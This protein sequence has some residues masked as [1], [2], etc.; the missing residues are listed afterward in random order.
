MNSALLLSTAAV[1]GC[2]RNGR[3][4]LFNEVLE[5]SSLLGL[6][7]TSALERSRIQTHLEKHQA[8]NQDEQI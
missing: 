5:P 6:F 2:T 8:K 7:V 3:L 4:Q 1:S